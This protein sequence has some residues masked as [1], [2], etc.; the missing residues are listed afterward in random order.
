MGKAYAHEVS[1]KPGAEAC[2]WPELPLS[3][4]PVLSCPYQTENRVLY[5]VPSVSLSPGS[6]PSA[7]QPKGKC[8]HLHLSLPHHCPD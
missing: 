1:Q 4:L 8:L 6:L 5:L 2:E 3:S 7:S